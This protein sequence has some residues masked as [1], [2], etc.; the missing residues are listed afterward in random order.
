MIIENGVLVKVEDGDIKKGLIK[1]DGIEK[2][3]NCQ[4]KF[5]QSES[6]LF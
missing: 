3:S 2:L 6:L 5:T 4:V 1:S